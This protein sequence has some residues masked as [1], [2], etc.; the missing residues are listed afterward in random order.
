MSEED[1][2]KTE[3][4][5][6]AEDAPVAAKEAPKKKKNWLTV[7]KWTGIVLLAVILLGLV[8]RDYIV[9]G[10]VPKI[11]EL[12]TGTPVKL[13]SF[14]SSFDGKVR[15]EG[16]QV[17]N[18]PGY[19][20]PNALVLESIYVKVNPGTLFSNRIE[21][22]EIIIKGLKTNY[23]MR[24]DGSSNLSDIEK[25]I[26]KYNKKSRKKKDRDDKE[27]KPEESSAGR[28]REKAPKKEVVI[29]LVKVSDSSF[30]LSSQL[31][32]SNVNLVLPPVELTEIGGGSSLGDTVYALYDQVLL[33][34]LQGAG[35][36]TDGL[37][38][39]GKTFKG[40][41]D[42]LLDSAGK[43]AKPAG[44]VITQLGD[45][46]LKEPEKAEENKNGQAQ[47]APVKE[48][49]KTDKKKKKEETVN[50]I[51]GLA[52][53]FLKAPEEKKDAP[54]NTDPVK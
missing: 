49:E 30:S 48:G 24:L 39:L 14:S 21:V 10:L 5:A 6:A 32:K 18:P 1:M 19:Q 31:L 9:M 7:L 54:K 38:D 41:S 34:I 26:D 33:V 2:K 15:L 11:G 43:G 52:D 4:A 3:A 8:F 40:V 47:P 37:S 23:E 20:Q 29:H 28:E 51:K 25:N 42:T 16:L 27:E 46:F 17:G 45:L 35:V 13:A 36:A 44:E 12:V 22:D 50:A 53:M